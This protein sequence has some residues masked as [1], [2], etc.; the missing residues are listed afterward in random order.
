MLAHQPENYQSIEDKLKLV[1][2]AVWCLVLH[3]I[4]YIRI[5]HPYCPLPTLKW[6]KTF[7][8]TMMTMQFFR[9]GW[10]AKQPL[11]IQRKMPPLSPIQ[12][13]ITLTLW[14]VITLPNK[15]NIIM[16]LQSYNQSLTIK[17]F[18][19]ENSMLFLSYNLKV[20]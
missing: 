19:V 5:K 11:K 6:F 12:F 15:I 17:I 20:T 18:K 4:Q 16:F 13:V 2:E 8:L 1:Q 7:E 10:G 9:G 14:T 3:S